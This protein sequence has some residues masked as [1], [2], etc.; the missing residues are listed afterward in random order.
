MTI[1]DWISA[2]TLVSMLLGGVV[3]VAKKDSTLDALIQAMREV[4][5]ALESIKAK[6]DLIEQ[7]AVRREMQLVELSRRVEDH[8]ARLRLIEKGK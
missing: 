3:L 8:E 4:Q 2:L 7:E 1:G 5:S 6:L